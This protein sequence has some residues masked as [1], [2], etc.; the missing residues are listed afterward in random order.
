VTAPCQ[1]NSKKENE[2]I[3]KVSGGELWKDK[4]KKKQQ[5]RH[6]CFRNQATWSDHG[7]L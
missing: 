3:K 7:W 4:P 5:K 1:R 6:R 2:A